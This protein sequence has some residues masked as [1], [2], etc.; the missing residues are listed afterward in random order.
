MQYKKSIISTGGKVPVNFSYSCAL[1]P[2]FVIKRNAEI[3]LEKK[4]QLGLEKIQTFFFFIQIS[5]TRRRAPEI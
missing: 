5:G 2:T 3:Q 4:I 1:L